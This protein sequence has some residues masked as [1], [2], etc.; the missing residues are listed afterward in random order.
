MQPGK[1]QI[2]FPL[3]THRSLLLTMVFHRAKGFPRTSNPKG[4]AHLG[5]HPK[6]VH[7]PIGKPPKHSVP[8]E[9]VIS[10][11][12]LD[13]YLRS[14]LC[15]LRTLGPKFSEADGPLIKRSASTLQLRPRKGFCSRFFT[16]V[17]L[18]QVAVIILFYR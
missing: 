6:I 1:G 17:K 3:S 8:T 12:I 9:K 13:E 18:W 11:S 14:W 5:P 7:I 16:R 10:Y 15:F 2:M 4:L